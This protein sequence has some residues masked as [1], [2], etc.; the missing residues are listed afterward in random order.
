MTIFVTRKINFHEV[1]LDELEYICDLNK[2]IK[3]CKPLNIIGF[4]FETTGLDP[5]LS[6]LS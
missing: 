5:Y 2:V 4:D 1:Q 6:D 3:Y